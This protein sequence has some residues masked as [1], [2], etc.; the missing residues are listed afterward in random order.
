MLTSSWYIR[1]PSLVTGV[2]A[3]SSTEICVVVVTKAYVTTK[4]DVMTST[5]PAQPS[6]TSELPTPISTT[7]NSTGTYIT[8]NNGTVVA[9]HQITNQEYVIVAWLPLILAAIYSILWRIVDSTI[10]E[11]EP[12]FQLQRSGGALAHHSLCL[13]YANSWII[14]L[15]FKAIHRRHFRVLCSSL[16]SIA[17]LVIA[18]LSAEAFFVSLSGQCD[19]SNPG[20]CYATWGIYPLLAHTISAM[21][22][23]IAVLTIALIAFHFRRQPGVFSNPLGIGGL[24]PLIQN[25]ALLRDFRGIN[26]MASNSELM[27]ELAGRRYKLGWYAD[28]D[29]KSFYGVVPI[30]CYLDIDRATRPDAAVKS[31]LVNENSSGSSINAQSATPGLD[32]SPGEET[33]VPDDQEDSSSITRANGTCGISPAL[34]TTENPELVGHETPRP[35]GTPQSSQNRTYHPVT[36]QDHDEN[37]TPLASRAILLLDREFHSNNGTN[38][39]INRSDPSEESMNPPEGDKVE[40]NSRRPPT[41]IIKK[42][43]RDDKLVKRIIYIIALV[44]LGFLLGMIIYYHYT[45]GPKWI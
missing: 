29:E 26:S 44:I 30:N 43:T 20:I 27:N 36:T 17:L 23:F 21:L 24:A 22:G 45:I 10:R 34:V 31:L 37:L 5:A 8:L 15:P 13:D 28:I 25:E 18:P 32:E 12:F 11:M 35:L 16:I 4:W 1:A 7:V 33:M 40:G 19:L 38:T 3:G 6:K 41:S 42:I 39:A 2:C 14:T 9:P